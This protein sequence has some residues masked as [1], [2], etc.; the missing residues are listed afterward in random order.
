MAPEVALDLPYNYSCDTYSFGIL[1][2]QIITL[3]VPYS[4]YTMKMH[5][6][7]VVRDGHRPK[8]DTTWPT[9]WIT[10][11]ELCWSSNYYKRPTFT[12]LLDT[13]NDIV[14]DLEHIDDGIVPTKTSLINAKKKRKKLATNS[15]QLDTDTR[16]LSS[17]T[18]TTN[19]TTNNVKNRKNGTIETVQLNG[20]D[21]V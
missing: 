13:I 15:I 8:I 14:L 18:L 20:H 2:W 16:I 7:Y 6:D 11:M 10:V 19:T 12:S 3:I 4:K 21:I 17:L 1:F 9:E 5:A